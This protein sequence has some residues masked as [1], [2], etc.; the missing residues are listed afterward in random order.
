MLDSPESTNEELSVC[1]RVIERI[2]DV[3]G[4]EPTSLTPLYEVID[5]DSLDNLFAP[6]MSGDRARGH[7]VFSY[8]GH[9]VSV[10]GDGRIELDDP[11]A[12]ACLDNRR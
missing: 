7:V 11:D 12:A 2:A 3:E 5:P 6:T 10:R 8:N 9:V 1:E 4:V